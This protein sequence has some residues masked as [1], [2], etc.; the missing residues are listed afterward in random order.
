[1]SPVVKQ[2][3]VSVDAYFPAGNWFDLFNYSNSLSV[4]SGKTITLDAPADH[5]NVHVHEGNILALQGAA[6]TTTEARKTEF[7]LLVVISGA[8]NST[9]QLF[10]DDGESAEM[11]AEGGQWSFVQFTGGL[12]GD[13]VAVSSTVTNGD[14][15]ASQNWT[16]TKVTFIGIEKTE[17]Q[18]SILEKTGLSLPVGQ[19]FSLQEKV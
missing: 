1:M 15:A 14:F 19:A 6:N 16:I 17:G 11:G 10:L 8:G 13:T 9:G 2:D 12:V 5:I 4:D 3:A 7:Q 18:F